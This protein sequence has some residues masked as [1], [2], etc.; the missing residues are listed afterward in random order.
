MQSQTNPR[1]TLSASEFL[2]LVPKVVATQQLSQSKDSDAPAFCEISG[3]GLSDRP[4]GNLCALHLPVEWTRIVDRQ[5][6]GA[7]I[8]PERDR[9]GLPAKPA[10]ELGPMAMIHQEVQQRTALLIRHALEPAGIGVIHEQAFA[11]C[12]RMDAHG[13]MHVLRG[14]PVGI[15]AHLARSPRIQ[16]RLR[17][18]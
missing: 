14:P 8:V 6:L 15:L 9:A 17:S 16:S 10:G 1:Y 12:F 18:G 13:R 11:A 2:P 3:L 5:V 7:T 4:A